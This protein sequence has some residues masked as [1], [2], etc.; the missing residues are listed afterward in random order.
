MT[1][2]RFSSLPDMNPTPSP[3]NTSLPSSIWPYDTSGT[4]DELSNQT[5]TNFFR[6]VS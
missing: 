4:G 2:R 1:M 6:T 5:F 3:L